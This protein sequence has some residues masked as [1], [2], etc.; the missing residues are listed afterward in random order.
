VRRR[1]GATLAA[2]L[3]SVAATAHAQLP[4]RWPRAPLTEVA[5]ARVR[6]DTARGDYGVTGAGGT[7]CLVDTGVDDAALEGLRA[8][9]A[10]AAPGRGHPLEATSGGAI[11]GPEALGAA[12]PD[13]HGHGTAMAS[14][15]TGPDGV[16]PGAAIL[17]AAAWD[18]DA[19]G[20]ED[21]AVVRAITW[22]RA[23]AAADPAVD[24]ARL[25][26]LLALGGHD[27][28]H[29]GRGEFERAIVEAA[30][31]IPVVVAAGND[32]DRAVH[33]AGRVW[34]GESARIEVRVPRP[35]IDDAAVALTLAVTPPGRARLVAPG[36]DRSE[37]LDGPTSRALGGA[38]IEA[39]AR[40][41]ALAV[42]IGAGATTLPSGEWAIEIEGSA[43]FEVWLAG[44]RLGAPFFGP[45]L[46]G[47][48][49]IED[50]AITIPA[51][52]PPLISVG[53]TV[54]RDAVGALRSIGAPGEVAD[55]SSRGP[56]AAGAPE[57]DLVAP[58]G[59]ILA[60]RSSDLRRG[61]TTNLV[62]GRDDYTIDG[63]VAVR[64][65]SAAAAVVA[66]ALLLALELDPSG[67]PEA[68]ARLVSSLDDPGW[69][70]A[71]G[72]GELDV[73]RLLERWSGGAAVGPDL[74]AGR[75][76]LA[77]HDRSLWLT[78][79]GEGETLRVRAGGE[80]ETA[81][82]RGGAALLELPLGSL[83]AGEALRVE[84][85]IDDT[86]LTPLE[87]AVVPDR[88]RPHVLRGGGCAAAPSAPAP[89]GLLWLAL[90]ARRRRARR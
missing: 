65:S 78:A 59:W 88:R 54:A 44:A 45:S 3:L 16:A 80:W 83:A 70:P 2:A 34:A 37:P 47:D 64:G 76:A 46:G 74:T 86:P 82:L 62:G 13:V 85:T 21:E 23:W 24:P 43:Q 6:A 52:A 87:V 71:R 58:G 53:A 73:P 19:G 67:G 17:A 60:A 48:F 35:T 41:G 72:H 36:G 14:I 42:T 5:R 18:A 55:F 40:G 75:A 11:W 57:P 12:P 7:L 1:G 26:I 50:E 77:V 81:S 29:D 10:P 66:G 22:C 25:V 8:V 68:R 38:R 9:F 51:T 33:A 61:D 49:V 79:R 84:A 63:R 90:L 31:P 69:S 30:G 28:A 39:E 15:A 4:P 56:T 20:F 32:G 89:L 27:G